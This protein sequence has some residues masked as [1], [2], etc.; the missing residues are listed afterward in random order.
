MGLLKNIA[1]NASAWTPRAKER[2]N[3]HAVPPSIKETKTV[4]T[5]TTTLVAITMAAIAA[6]KPS[7]RMLLKNIARNASAWTPR[8]KDRLNPHAVPPSIKETKTVTTTT[9]TLV[10]I[11]M[12]AIAA[13]KPS[14]RTLL[15][16]IAK[17]ASAWTPK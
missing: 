9:T 17:Y 5:R 13:K 1:R 8:A 2:L 3:P 4:T 16:N 15:K 11:T 10:A 14:G 12:A 7:G 6:K